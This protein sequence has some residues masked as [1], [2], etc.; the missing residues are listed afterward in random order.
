[1]ELNQT[2]ISYYD[3]RLQ[4]IV[5]TTESTDAIVP[6]TLPD[7]GRVVCAYGTAAIKDQTPQ[8]DRLLISGTVNTTVLYQPD[9]D[10]GMR[11]VQVPISF[12]HIE[13]CSGLDAGAVC[14]T[15][16][17]VSGVEAVPVNSRKLTVSAQLCFESEGYQKA[18]CAV[19]ETID[20]PK[21]EVLSAPTTVTLIEQMQQCPL[22]VLEDVTLPDAAD[23][24]LL[25]ADCAL[26]VTDCRAMPG[27][28]VLKG[29]ASI[30]CLAMQEDDA[31]RVLGSSTPFT[32]ILDVPDIADGD[33]VSAQLSVRELDCRLEPD[34]LLSYTVNVSALLCKRRT[35]SLQDITDL[36]LPGKE[37]HLQQEKVALRSLPAPTAFTGEVSETLQTAQRVSHVVSASACCCGA[38]K[39]DGEAVQMTVAVQILFLN[40]D[41]QL[42]AMQR[43]LPLSVPCAAR[44]DMAQ[45]ELTANASPSG[46]KGILL[47][48]H[49][50][51]Q[52][53]AESACVLRCISN[54]E[55]AE[56]E[57]NLGGVTL[58]LRFIE[59]EQPLWDIAKSC[60]T[61]IEVIRRANDLPSDAAAAAN[62]MLLIPIQR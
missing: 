45:I 21:V 49:A 18:T 41:Q 42:C 1:M 54:V 28:V 7:I 61:T 47:T 57:N 40:E 13:E 16:C 11:R 6:D 19:T 10:G 50:A 22:T 36:Y 20:L 58:I 30:S 34:G 60:G 52:L 33:A 12:A 17:R 31:I 43:T 44:G 14:H 62:T 23:L 27:K 59:Q 56:A 55:I 37:L 35:Q 15:V 4:R 39:A 25:H 29:E 5:T 2:S 51:A 48:V 3:R 32:Q 24:S 53:A 46:E 9:G 26:R 8:S 38:K